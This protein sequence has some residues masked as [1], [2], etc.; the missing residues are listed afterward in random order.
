[1][2]KRMLVA[3]VIALL[4]S[5]CQKKSTSSSMSGQ[6]GS[7]A[8]TTMAPQPEPPTT[9]PAAM[10]SQADRK[11]MD[12]AAQGGRL[13]VQ[14]GKDAQQQASAQDVKSFGQ[15]MVHDHEKVNQGLMQLAQ[16][17]GVELPSTLDGKMKAKIQ[18]LSGLQGVAF[19]QAYMKDMVT[20]HE[21]DVAAFQSEAQNGQDPDVKAFAEK[22]VKTLEEHLKMARDTNGKAQNEKTGNK[23]S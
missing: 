12:E 18:H 13:E 2:Y 15:H 20:D 11:F 3:A 7:T 10:L 17:K 9:R 4:L 21:E 8:G 19:D 22:T 14:L 6:P 1:M 23:G 16:R 5:G